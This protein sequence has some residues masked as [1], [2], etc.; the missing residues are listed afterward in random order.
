MLFYQRQV[1][2]RFQQLKGETPL[3]PRR[4]GAMDGNNSAKRV[5]SAALVD[6]AKFDSDYFLSRDEVDEYKDEVKGR[7]RTDTRGDRPA[8][9]EVRLLLIAGASD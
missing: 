9:R 8:N 5:A 4:L 2:S 3:R 7:K 1:D 6:S